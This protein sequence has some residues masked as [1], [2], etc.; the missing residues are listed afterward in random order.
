MQI[1]NIILSHTYILLT[2]YQICPSAMYPLFVIP[3]SP[4]HSTSN[5]YLNDNSLKNVTTPSYA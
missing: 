4:I 1:H 3:I 2:I 5:T